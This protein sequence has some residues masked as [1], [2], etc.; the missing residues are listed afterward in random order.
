[1]SAKIHVEVFVAAQLLS[2]RQ[3]TFTAEALRQEVKRLF[4]DTRPGVGTHISAHCVANAPRNAGTVYNY[5]WRLEQGLLR[6]F[7]PVKDRPHTS[8]TDAAWFPRR[9]DVPLRYQH[10]LPQDA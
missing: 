5:L 8:R 10:L 9:G 4:G 1:M 2:R 3:E 7:D 6:A